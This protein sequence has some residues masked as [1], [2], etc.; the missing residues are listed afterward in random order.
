MILNSVSCIKYSLLLCIVRRFCTLSHYYKMDWAQLNC[1]KCHLRKE[2]HLF[3]YLMNKF[4]SSANWALFN[5]SPIQKVWA[6][7]CP[8]SGSSCLFTIPLIVQYHKLF[9]TLEA[10]I[11]WG[12]LLTFERQRG[13]TAIILVQRYTLLH[14]N[15]WFMSLLLCQ[16]VNSQYL[17]P[18]YIY[19]PSKTNAY[20]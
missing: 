19:A 7:L 14:L 8:Y 1:D 5:L 10:V 13:I 4:Y 9:K 16:R 17:V 18:H 2:F 11:L 20:S 12:R 3:P 6:L 15:W